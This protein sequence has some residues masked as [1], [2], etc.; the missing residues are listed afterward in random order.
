MIRLLILALFLVFLLL[1]AGAVWRGLARRDI[2][3]TGVTLAFGFIAMAFYLRH[4]T[5]MG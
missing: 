3:W 5:G 4:V 2:D 1:V